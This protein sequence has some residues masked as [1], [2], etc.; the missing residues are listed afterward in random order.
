MSKINRHLPLVLLS[1]TIV[2][3]VDVLIFSGWALSAICLAWGIYMASKT[4]LAP[5]RRCD[6]KVITCIVIFV[7]AGIIGYSVNAYVQADF[8]R[9]GKSSVNIP[10]DEGELLRIGESQLS[11]FS[12]WCFIGYVNVDGTAVAKLRMFPYRIAEYDLNSGE[13]TIRP[14]D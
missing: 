3:A 14:Y 4:V 13:F 8:L 1:C 7:T 2:I 9:L 12:K 11:W 10:K 6:F 5:G